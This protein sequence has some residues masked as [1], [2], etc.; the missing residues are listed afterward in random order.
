M[1]NLYSVKD[2]KL[3]LSKY[4]FH[5][6]KGL[7]Q[8]FISSPHLCSKIVSKSGIT[9][10]TGVIEIGPGIG[11]LTC[12]IASRA[13]KVVSVEI[14]KKLIPVLS[15]TVSYCGNVKIIN[16]DIL[17]VGITALIRDEFRD[18]EDIKVCA[19]LPYYIT[20]AVIMKL[21]EED[22]SIT[23]M[24]LMV[25]KEAADR[26][27]AL[28]GSRQCGALSMA[29]RYYA[30][31]QILFKVSKSCFIPSPK[32]DSCVIKITRNS[33]NSADVSDKKTFFRVV[34]SSFSQRRKTIINSL[35][36]EFA[37]D[38]DSLSEVLSNVGISSK[39]RPE[40][41]SFVDFV[42]LSNSIYNRIV[43]YI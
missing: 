32:V 3:L 16:S 29:V 40:Q 2:I 27:C 19:N 15:D 24:T 39:S 7:G 20:S 4:N 5:F 25:Q 8:N 43:Q 12:E 28:P 22:S 10:S 41:L 42:H 26:I 23:S 6:S 14:D 11:V 31:P 38:K 37:L 21:L 36:S 18:F 1:Y 35:N 13:K 17:K 30:D 34:K 33:K 9:E